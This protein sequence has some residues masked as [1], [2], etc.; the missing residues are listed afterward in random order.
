MPA[1][2]PVKVTS[3]QP[4]TIRSPKSGS[5]LLGSDAKK[6]PSSTLAEWS[7]LAGWSMP[8]LAEITL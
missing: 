2:V 4:V 6:P 1:L 3:L 5:L 7:S 8:V